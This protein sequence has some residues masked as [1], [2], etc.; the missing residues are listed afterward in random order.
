MHPAID[1]LL[2]I[3]KAGLKP[4]VVWVVFGDVLQTPFWKLAEGPVEIA[5]RPSDAFQRFDWRAVVGCDL[6]LLAEARSKPLA[7]LLERLQAF[8]ARITLY[9]LDL[10]PAEFGY[11]WTRSEP[12]RRFAGG[13]ERG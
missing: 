11:V 12:W 4:A 2:E 13:V 5:V 3:R 7:A 8:A 6:I 10:L 9:L 1:A